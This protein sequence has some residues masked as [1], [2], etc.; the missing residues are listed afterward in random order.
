[1]HILVLSTIPAFIVIAW[2]LLKLKRRGIINNNKLAIIC[3]TY[4]NLQFFLI[5]I[6]EILSFN[7]IKEIPYTFWVLLLVYSLLLWLIGY[8]VLRWLFNKSFTKEDK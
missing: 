2:F 7:S 3:I 6:D 8:P 5:G 1:M 4:V